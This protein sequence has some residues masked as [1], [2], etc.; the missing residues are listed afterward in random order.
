MEMKFSVWATAGLLA[1]VLPTSA[2][3]YSG[4]LGRLQVV[5]ELQPANGK[6]VRQGRYFYRHQGVDVPLKG[7]ADDLLEGLPLD[8]QMLLQ[9][10]QSAAA[11]QTAEPPVFKDLQGHSLHWQGQVEGDEYRGTWRDDRQ[12]RSHPFVLKR[13]T[14]HDAARLDAG[15]PHPPADPRDITATAQLYEFLRLSVPL[16]QGPLTT[17]APG[18]AWRLVQDRRTQF[19]FPRL[20]QHPD[21]KVVARVN[22]LLEQQHWA[23]SRDALDCRSSQYLQTFAGAGTLA[24]YEKH[25]VRVTYLTPSL[26]SVLAQGSTVCGGPPQHEHRPMT[27][28]LRRGEPLDFSRIF[29]G[30]DGAL[31]TQAFAEFVQSLQGAPGVVDDDTGCADGWPEGMALYFKA[32]AQLAVATSRSNGVQQYCLATHMTVPLARLKPLLRPGAD[33]YLPDL[34]RQARPAALE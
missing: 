32:P 21:A 28:D 33:E 1:W 18:L 9:L 6:G 5:M 24:G 22:A 10:Q 14:A 27:F 8:A 2:Q 4:T 19:W 11:G 23:M 34:R 30:V 25:S 31:Y 26:M 7:R 16:R 12:G 17:V 3:I 15:R 20:A 29:T 13:V